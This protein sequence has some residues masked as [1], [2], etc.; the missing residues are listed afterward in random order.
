MFFG[1]FALILSLHKLINSR[2][3]H[4]KLLGHEITIMG[5]LTVFKTSLQEFNVYGTDEQKQA[6]VPVRIV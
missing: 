6:S 3:S 2:D 5:F 1:G 4:I